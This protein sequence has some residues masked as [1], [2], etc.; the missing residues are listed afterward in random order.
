[1]S[2][3]PASQQPDAPDR[4]PVPA[5][6]SP[7]LEALLR[8]F[9]EL[10]PGDGDAQGLRQAIDLV[11][12]S[13]I[14]ALRLPVAQG[15]AGA[16]LQQLYQLVLR[17]AE[18]NSNLAHVLRN[19]FGFVERALYSAEL[20][21][22]RRW[23]QDAADG[24]LFGLGSTE[25]GTATV[26]VGTGNTRLTPDGDG[27]RLNGTKYYSTGNLYSDRLYVHAQLE[28]DRQVVAV[29]PT[30]REG[31]DVRD[32]WDAFGQKLSASGT[33]LLR[34]VRVESD[35][36]IGIDDQNRPLPVQSTF[37]QLY[38]TSIVTGILNA[39]VRDA[40]A[41][42]VNR[43]RNYY[44]AVAPIPKD[45]P[46]LQLSI[47]RLSAVAYVAES[48]V[49]RAADALALAHETAQQGEVDAQQFV[50]AGL[51]AAKAKIV[52]DGLALEAASGLFD[53]AGASATGAR[54]ALD[55]H[56]RN[57]R[58]V[59]SHN[60]VSYKARSIGQHELDGTPLPG[61]GFF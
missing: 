23:L 59:S 6:G 25:L 61:F 15:G 4:A 50:D 19:H 30:R 51:A 49:L 57:V 36:V 44:H 41:L 28:D 29:I 22:Y 27:W 13:R 20:P 32:D 55:R 7:E 5:I 18:V 11:R 33:T 42:L 17:I 46:L 2:L 54:Q 43:G 52:I 34:D 9:A 1:M 37:F 56:W 10:L 60:P 26:G 38:L 48:A 35:E 45:D 39:I 8:K 24:L 12:S 21:K 58:T 31:V 16:S 40:K 3:T 53:V 14:G 47:G